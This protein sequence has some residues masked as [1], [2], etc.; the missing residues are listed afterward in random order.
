[1]KEYS[2]LVDFE[3]LEILPKS[4]SRRQ[5]VIE[6]IQCLKNYHLIEPD[7]SLIDTHSSRT[8]S[9]NLVSGFSIVWWADGSD[10][11]VK[12]VE[13]EVAD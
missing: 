4:G 13:I 12:V 5:S 10:L 8:L 6:F 1:M 3:A 7:Y 9:V 11:E 2:V